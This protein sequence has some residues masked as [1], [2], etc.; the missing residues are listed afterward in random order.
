MENLKVIRPGFGLA[1]KYL[2]VILGKK[3]PKD[4]QAGTPLDWD[5]LLD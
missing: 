5:L 1:P 2:E 4:I 3:A